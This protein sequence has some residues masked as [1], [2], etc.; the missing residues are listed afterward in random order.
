[1]G[2]TSTDGRASGFDQRAAKVRDVFARR[3]R[4]GVGPAAKT[5]VDDAKALVQ[6]EIALAKAELS[7][8]LKE[9]GT[10][11]GLFVGAG[12]MAW[13][14]IQGVLITLGFVL[15]IWLPGWA[16]ALIVTGV[17]L[18][19][20][21]ILALVGRKKLQAPAGVDVTKQNVEEDLTWTKAHLPDRERLQRADPPRT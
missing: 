14:G 12:V 11:I 7:S 17:L 18:L 1:M 3:P 10:G 5:V 15:A 16:A 4:V 20:G 8:G 19:L 2:A 6:A 13:L 21:A 9:K